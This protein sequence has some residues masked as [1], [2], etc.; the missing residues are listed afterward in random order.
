MYKFITNTGDVIRISDNVVIAPTSNPEGVDYQEYLNWS[1]LGGTLTEEYIP[2]LDPIQPKILPMYEW[3]DK[4]TTDEQIALL[5]KAYE[6]DT[7]CRLILF[8]SQTA[9][10]LDVNSQ[11]VQDA[12]LYMLSI[13]LLAQ[14]RYDELRV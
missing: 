10:K 2:E 4:F 7:Y 9:T 14:A 6:G 5:N 11:T 1:R 3:R 13:G 12:L 8:K